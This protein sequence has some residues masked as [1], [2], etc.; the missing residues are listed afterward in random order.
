MFKLA[1]ERVGG[2]ENNTDGWQSESEVAKQLSLQKFNRFV[3]SLDQLRLAGKLALYLA[4]YQKHN[5]LL[6]VINDNTAA[7]NLS[8]MLG[9]KRTYHKIILSNY[10]GETQNGNILKLSTRSFFAVLNIMAKGV[11]ATGLFSVYSGDSE[12]QNA[13]T[14]IEY[15]NRWYYIS[16]SDITSKATLILLKFI[17]ALQAGEITTSSWPIF[18]IPDNYE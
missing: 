13:S 4:N 18:N 5:V 2:L 3:D 8:A 16:N 9:L 10:C 7:A 17:Y 15:E 11:D 6:L 12:P 1:V 14:K